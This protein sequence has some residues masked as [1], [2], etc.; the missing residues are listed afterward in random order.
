MAWDRQKDYDK[1][2]ALAQK[3]NET[4]R[5]LLPYNPADHR[6]KVDGIIARF[7]RTFVEDR[8]DWGNPSAVPVFIVGMP[9][10]GTTLAEQIL[11]G[12]SKVHGAGELSLSGDAIGRLD[13]W[14]KK[15]GS[16]LSYPTCVAD[17][18]RA[19]VQRMAGQWLRDL[20]AHDGDALYVIDKLP[21]NF[22]QI[23][24]IKLL[25]PNA[26][27]FNCRRE[28]RD[29]AVSNYITDFAAKFGGM[30]F[31]YD[32]AWIGEQVVDHDRLMQ[33]WS[34][35]YPDTIMDV[36]YEDTV[37][38]TEAQAR[39]MISF[40]GLGW[41][42]EVLDFQS[43]DRSVRTASSWQVR[44]PVYKTSKAR[45]MNYQAHLGPLEAALSVSPPLPAPLPDPALPP[46]LFVEGTG[47][48]QQNKPDAAAGLFA[49]ILS[50]HP[51]HAAAHHFLGVAQMQ[52]GH[53][54]AAVVSMRKSVRLHRF[55]A[56]WFQNLAAV[57][58]VLGHTKNAAAARTV[59]AK[60]SGR[61]P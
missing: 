13:L 6:A 42:P 10:S 21:H 58:D 5:T 33:H 41:E 7:S 44:Q 12:H 23:G 55:H 24:L 17:L 8:K 20:Q 49:Q 18:R 52:Q 28:A 56:S 35:L 34:A 19:D 36:V 40:L 3:A 30:G 37:A 26:R 47:L 1:A 61:R 25:F 53:V 2:F 32:L 22:E 54:D 59:A 29:I 38:D 9:R 39:R 51:D 57:E 27:I 16:R 50:V 45:W 48:L 4:S 43:L 31:A 14:E 11:A 46:G 15:I 60:L